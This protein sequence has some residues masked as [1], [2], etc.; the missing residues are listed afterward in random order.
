MFSGQNLSDEELKSKMKEIENRYSK[1]I[2]FS[3]SVS[4]SDEKNQQRDIVTGEARTF[5]EYKENVQKYLFE[6]GSYIYLQ[7]DKKEKI[8]VSIYNFDRSWGVSKSSTALFAFPSTVDS[9]SEYLN[10]VIDEFGLGTGKIEFEWD[11]PIKYEIKRPEEFSKK[12]GKE[13]AKVNL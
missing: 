9:D 10:L 3:L 5:D 8:E 6:L 12:F 4:F 1:S 13:I 7:T 2:Y 11:L